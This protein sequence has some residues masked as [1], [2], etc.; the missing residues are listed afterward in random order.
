MRGWEGIQAP[1]ASSS[2]VSETAVLIAKLPTPGAE[3]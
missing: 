3:N 2:A 1:D